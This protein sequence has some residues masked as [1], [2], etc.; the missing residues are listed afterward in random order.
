MSHCEAPVS[1]MLL[2]TLDK[3]CGRVY[4]LCDGL[5][6]IKYTQMSKSGGKYEFHMQKM[7]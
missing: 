6:D 2:V 7:I 5:W 4:D 1:E 3:I